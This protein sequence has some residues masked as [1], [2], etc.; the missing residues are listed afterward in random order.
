MSDHT[1]GPWKFREFGGEHVLCTNHS[2]SLIVLGAVRKGMNG[3]TFR[4]RNQAECRMIPFDQEHPDA[5]LIAEAPAMELILQMVSCGAANF[6]G[7]GLCFNGL[8]YSTSCASNN[9]WHHILD[10][11]G[12]ENA[13]Q[14]VE[15]H[16]G[17][18]PREWTNE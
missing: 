11:I 16:R 12:W 9:E 17:R 8:C 14:A 2:G 13:R 10:L 4:V 5:K 6:S 3:A 1:P 15:E 7:G 18:D